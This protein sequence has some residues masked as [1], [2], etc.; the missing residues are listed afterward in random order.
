[1][2]SIA[3][4]FANS[5]CI[6]NGISKFFDKYIGS[7]LLQKCGIKKIVDQLTIDTEPEYADNPI[8]RLVGKNVETSKVLQKVVK[9]KTLLIDKLLLCFHPQSAYRMFKTNTFYGDYK[10]D[11]FYR[12]DQMPSA[13]WERLQLETARNVIFDIESRTKD[14]QF[15]RS[16]F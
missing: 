13:N 7:R 8:L 16:R 9:A 5:N 10:K 4:F 15:E 6:L 11:T 12:F 2:N 1:M 3:E 14:D